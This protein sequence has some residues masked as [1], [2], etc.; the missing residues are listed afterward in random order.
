LGLPARKRW[1]QFSFS[2][3]AKVVVRK[4]SRGESDTSS[5]KNLWMGAAEVRLSVM[6]TPNGLGFLLFFLPD[7]KERKNRAQTM[8]ST[9]TQKTMKTQAK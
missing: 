1:R 7:Q 8:L 4:V 2:F 3:L 5:I 9:R 6:I